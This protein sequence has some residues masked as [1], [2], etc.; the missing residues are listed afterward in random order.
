MKKIIPKKL[1]SLIPKRDKHS[2]KGDYGKVLI[3]A[4]S[5]G[6]SGAAI[7]AG[8]AA[9]KAGAGLIT[10]ACPASERFIIT[11]ALPEAMTL[12]LSDKDGVFS[13]KAAGEILKW[14][15]IKKY[16]VA[17][18]GPG[19]SVLKEA[20]LFAAEV[21]KKLQIPMIIDADA[22]NAL[23]LKPLSASSLPRIMTPHLGEMKRLVKTGSSDRKSLAFKLFNKTGAII[24]MKGNKTLIKAKDD[25]YENTTGGPSLSKGGSGDVLA[26]LIAGL[27]AQA[28]KRDGYNDKTAFESSILGVYLHGLCGDLA[29]KKLT[30]RCVLAGELL[31]YLPNAYRSLSKI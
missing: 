6:M 5:K 21:I 11:A 15:K 27:W 13:L 7:L 25:F 10:I 24:I 20:P 8:R 12:P 26:G 1:K 9:L 4:G 19:L 22:L 17:L 16:D 3:I 28:G 18:I 2:H 30:E 14:Q 23:A 29:S 31:D